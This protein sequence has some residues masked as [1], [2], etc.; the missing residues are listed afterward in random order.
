MDLFVA[1][2]P[3]PIAAANLCISSCRN[4][5]VSNKEMEQLIDALLDNT[6]KEGSVPL[7]TACSGTLPP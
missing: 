3:Q 2:S 5:E 6:G 4:N 7:N 1:H